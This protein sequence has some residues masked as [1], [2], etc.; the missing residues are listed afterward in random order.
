M[1][2]SSPRLS[3]CTV[4]FRLN[5]RSLCLWGRGR[6]V[7]GG[8]YGCTSGQ[9]AL[10][11]RPDPRS[12]SLRICLLGFNHC[13]NPLRA[14]N[15]RRRR[16]WRH[17][18]RCLDCD[19]LV[20]SVR[21]VWRDRNIKQSGALTERCL[22]ARQNVPKPRGALSHSDLRNGYSL[23]LYRRSISSPSKRSSPTCNQAPRERSAGKSSTA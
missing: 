10:A 2:R 21:I 16:S 9:S 15:P 5:P 17:R 12:R 1:G 14:C 8:H 7:R 6:A 18:R 19:W 3:R 11:A 13:S 4:C 23:L 22:L 20:V